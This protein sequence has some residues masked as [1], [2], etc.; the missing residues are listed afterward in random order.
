MNPFT[1][2]HSLKMY[3]MFLFCFCEL[4]FMPL[5]CKRKDVKGLEE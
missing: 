3:Q 2:N 5:L 4:G 1:E